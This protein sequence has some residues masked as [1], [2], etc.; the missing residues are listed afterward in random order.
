MVDSGC[1]N[2]NAANGGSLGLEAACCPQGDSDVRLEGISRQEGCQGRG[3]GSHIVHPKSCVLPCTS[4]PF[5]HHGLD[6]STPNPVSSNLMS[7][8]AHHPPMFTMALTTPLQ[9]LCL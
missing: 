5:F 4:P 8:P 9:I 6:D 1:A 7:F 3:R 2:K